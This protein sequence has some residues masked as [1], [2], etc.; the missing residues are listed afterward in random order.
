MKKYIIDVCLF[1]LFVSFGVFAFIDVTINKKEIN[2]EELMQNV[3]FVLDIYGHDTLWIEY[4]T[5]ISKSYSI[6]RPKQYN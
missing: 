6:Q 2:K 3:H 4:D 5:T 1:L